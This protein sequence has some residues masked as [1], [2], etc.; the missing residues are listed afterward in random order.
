[1]ALVLTSVLLQWRISVNDEATVRGIGDF[2]AGR[3][4]NNLGS[5]DE[6]R[7]ASLPKRLPAAAAVINLDRER[8]KEKILFVRISAP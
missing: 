8:V 1:M 2:A 4:F 5:W 6:S 3:H 7:P